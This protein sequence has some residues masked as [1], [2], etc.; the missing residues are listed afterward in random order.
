[1]LKRI[2]KVVKI[3]VLGAGTFGFGTLAYH[4]YQK[5]E[6]IQ[7]KNNLLQSGTKI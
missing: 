3:L 2:P 6:N 7:I 5:N 1:M 4:Q